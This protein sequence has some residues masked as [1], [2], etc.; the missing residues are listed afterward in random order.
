MSDP[1][2][3]SSLQ[4]GDKITVSDRNISILLWVWLLFIHLRIKKE[5][6]K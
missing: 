1:P 2:Q 5:Q 6:R 3:N 4:L